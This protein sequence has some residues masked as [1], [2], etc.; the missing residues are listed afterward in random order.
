LARRRWILSDNENSRA[1]KNALH[2]V[3]KGGME[4]RKRRWS[5]SNGVHMKKST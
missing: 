5:G 1:P 2:G 3:L 4:E